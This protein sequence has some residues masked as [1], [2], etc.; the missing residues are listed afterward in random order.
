MI[1]ETHNQYSVLDTIINYVCV[2]N[3]QENMYNKRENLV[4]AGRVVGFQDLRLNAF[5]EVRNEKRC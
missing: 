4:C 2:F 1:N 3:L 5:L